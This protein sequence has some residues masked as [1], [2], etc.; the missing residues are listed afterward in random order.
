MRRRRWWI[1]GASVAATLLVGGVAS[2]NSWHRPTPRADA[3]WLGHATGPAHAVA[4]HPTKP[5]STSPSPA[6]TVSASPISTPSEHPTTPGSTPGSPGD[7]AATGTKTVTAPP[8]AGRFD[9]QIGGA[10][11]PDASVRIVSRDRT[12]PAVPGVYSICYVNAFQTQPG[13]EQADAPLLLH[14]ASGNR[15]KDEDWGEYL[16]DTRTAVA[17]ATLLATV[18]PWIDGCARSGYSGVEFDNFDSWDRSD[19]LISVQ[20]NLDAAKLLIDRAHADGLAAG[21]KNGAEVAEQGKALGFDFAI[22][23]QCQQYSEC[24]AYA[25]VY[26]GH[27]IEIEYT[28]NAFTTACAARAANASVLRRDVDVTPKGSSGYIS[29]WCAQ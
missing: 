22:A 11:A 27:L 4:P 5:G 25:A 8:V 17:R 12:D 24:D 23:E 14:D 18:G 21:Q 26:G 15:V 29:R 16:F 13:E 6:P 3:T 20:N 1:A 28:D 10:Y 2:A 19:G 7:P 9:Y